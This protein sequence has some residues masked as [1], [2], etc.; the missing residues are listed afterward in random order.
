MKTLFNS[1]DQYNLSPIKY[2]WAFDAYETARQNF[3][4]P[5][6]ISMS[7]DFA[8]FQALTDSEREMFLD[9]FATL[10]TSDLAIQENI[11]MRIYQVLTPPEI[12]LWL[13]HQLADESLH[14]YSYQHIIECLALNDESVYHRY[15]ERPYILQK[16]ELGN[17][18][19]AELMKD[20]PFSKTLGIAFFYLCWEGLW[21][22]HGFSPIFALGR[23]GLMPGTCE[24]LQYIAKDEVTHFQWGANLV[25]GLIAENNLSGSLLMAA[26]Q[27]MFLELVEAEAAYA[28]ACIRDVA[29]YSAQLHI[30]HAKYLA[31]LRLRQ[32]GVQPVFGV[33]E[34]VLPWL[35]EMIELKK[36]KNFFE[37]HVTEYQTG[38]K[39]MFDNSA[40]LEDIDGW[41]KEL[42]SH[43]R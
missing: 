23:R 12:R 14:S 39:L 26:F 9:V 5:K 31:D 32:V 33:T 35:S 7:R 13:G 43:G 18:Y 42:L 38:S 1:H 27:D 22:Y 24:Q 2:R 37:S 4:S 30:D 6:Q 41:R 21:F 20:D 40:T 8:S 28:N 19:A 15:K 10:T 25:K 36:E 29:G 3:W 17:R 16:F 11:A 34:S